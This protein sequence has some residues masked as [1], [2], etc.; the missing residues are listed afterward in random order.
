MLSGEM[1]ETAELGVLANHMAENLVP[2]PAR[3][4][5]YRSWGSLIGMLPTG[6]VRVWGNSTWAPDD[7]SVMRLAK[8]SLGCAPSCYLCLV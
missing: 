5:L 2:R 1:K 6:G 8:R 4:Q 3:V 7:D